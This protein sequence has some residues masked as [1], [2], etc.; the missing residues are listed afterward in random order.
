MVLLK[1]Y[2]RNARSFLQYLKKTQKKL[3]EEPIHQLRVHIKKMRAI[4]KLI[5]ISSQGEFKKKR[6]FNLFSRFFDYAG[7]LREIQ[8]NHVIIKKFRNNDIS[9]FEKHLAHHEKQASKKLHKA[10]VEFDTGQFEKLNS[11][12]RPVVAGM[13]EKKIISQSEKFISGEIKKIKKLMSKLS[14]HGDLH[15]IRIRLKSISAI[16]RPLETYQPDNKWAK[17]KKEIKPLGLLIGE[18]HDQQVL[19]DT[20]KQFINRS[21]EKNHEI[22]NVKK[23][24]KQIDRENKR[25]V[26]QVGQK[27]N[28]VFSAQ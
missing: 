9:V 6:H 12:I 7:N 2:D 22:E 16:L 17:L 11:Q 18:W 8:V 23:V 24:V 26:K 25:I 3:Q 20:M 4:L 5:E 21:Q 28:V 10:V 15:K 1:Y 19:A 27:L 14:N 13:E